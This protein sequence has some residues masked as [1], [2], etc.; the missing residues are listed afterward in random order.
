MNKNTEHMIHQAH[1]WRANKVVERP[2]IATGFSALDEMLGGWPQKAIT[3]ILLPHDDLDELHLLM[4][5][6]ARLS[7]EGR[8]IALIS[9]PHIPYAPVLLAHG[10][11]LSRVLLVH[12][13]AAFDTLWTVEQALRAGTC[14]AVIAWIKTGEKHYQ[15]RLQLAAEK[16]RSLGILFQPEDMAPST[17][18]AALR[19]KL[20]AA[21]KM[22]VKVHINKQHENWTS[23]PIFIEAA[24]RTSSAVKRP[25]LDH[26]SAYC[27]LQ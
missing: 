22:G 20:E 24:I 16:G 13:R 8:W 15:R 5:A 12:A 23:D 26:E 14:G 4:P 9:P 19:I 10:I 1:I 6:L 25:I 2:N 27:G 17:S 7:Q 18:S 3:E 11:D 21:S